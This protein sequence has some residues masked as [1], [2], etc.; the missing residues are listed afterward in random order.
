MLTLFKNARAR[1]LTQALIDGD[2]NRLARYNG[3]VDAEQLRQP[4]A[5]QGN[6]LELTLD[7]GQPEALEWVL[8]HCPDADGN[9]ARG[10]PY[11][12]QAMRH[13]SRSLALLSVLLQQGADPNRQHD[14]RTLL[15]WCFD[16]CAEEQ[17]MLHLSRLAQHGAELAD[18]GTLVER[19]LLSGQQ[20]L[21]HFLIH[22]GAPLPQTLDTLELDEALKAY[23][24]RC[25]EDRRIR[26]MMLGR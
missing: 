5:E 12:L 11:T 17:L 20:P 21:I 10:E 25:A 18:D 3:K 4:L 23:A 15:H 16:L 26:E 22:S 8:R 14:R 7:A 6:A 2:L 13:P 9:N 19:S 1:R 24:R